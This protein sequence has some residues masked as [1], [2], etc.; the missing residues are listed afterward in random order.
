[1]KM[2]TLPV[3]VNEKRKHAA[4]LLR[5]YDKMRAEMRKVEAEL[6]LAC[7]DYGRATGRWGFNRDHM[8]MEI[9]QQ[10]GKAA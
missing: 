3:D 1:M 9:E 5:K 2:Q 4:Q 10:K 8:R 7:T 6:S